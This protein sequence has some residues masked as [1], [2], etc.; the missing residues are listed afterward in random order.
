M[1]IEIDWRLEVFFFLLFSFLENFFFIDV[2][3]M[4]VLRRLIV[5]FGIIF[6]IGILDKFLLF[7]FIGLC[8]LELVEGILFGFCFLFLLVIVMFLLMKLNMDCVDLSE[9]IELLWFLLDWWWVWVWL[10][11]LYFVEMLVF[12]FC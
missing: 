10:S 12:F 1:V 6:I 9:F 4:F 11:L 2:D 7:E 3:C 5:L 8:F